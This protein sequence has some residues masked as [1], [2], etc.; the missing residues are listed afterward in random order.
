MQAKPFHPST[1]PNMKNK[2]KSTRQHSTRYLIHRPAGKLAI[3]GT[4]RPRIARRPRARRGKASLAAPRPEARAG[5]AESGTHRVGGG[6]GRRTREPLRGPGRSGRRGGGAARPAGSRPTRRV[7]PQPQLPQ[8]R[9]AHRPL[10]LPPRPPRPHPGGVGGWWSLPRACAP[11]LGGAT[12]APIAGTNRRPAPV[13]LPPPPPPA[14]R[15]AL[16][17]SAGLLAGGLAARPRLPREDPALASARRLLHSGAAAPSPR[18]AAPGAAP[19]AA[20]E[21]SAPS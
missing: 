1:D 6:G 5:Q 19:T 12:A 4:P 11:A 18:G 3:P 9:P 8:P 15:S 7:P 10:A 14:R 21:E 2:M 20:V 17:C 16:A 13:S